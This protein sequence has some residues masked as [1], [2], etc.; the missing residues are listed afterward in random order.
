[1]PQIGNDNLIWHLSSKY[2]CEV[3]VFLASQTNDKFAIEL[4][5]STEL[6]PENPFYRAEVKLFEESVFHL[7]VNLVT[8]RSLCH[9]MRP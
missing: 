4:G 1:M 8:V 9:I 6:V 2:G 5:I 7:P 3:R